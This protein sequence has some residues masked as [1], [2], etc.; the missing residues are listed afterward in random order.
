VLDLGT[1]TGIWAIDF[2]DE[3]PSA[4]VIG[5]DLS[6]IQPHWIPPNVRFEIEDF[7]DDWTFKTNE[8]DFIHMRS[9][10]S[11]VSDWRKFYRQAYE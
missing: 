8:F 5:T 4:S 3:Y 6:P 7:N 9:L 1:G 11:S 10:Y 2:A